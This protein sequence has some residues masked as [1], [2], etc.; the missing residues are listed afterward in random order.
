MST[1]LPGHFEGGNKFSITN[2][3][4][5]TKVINFQIR[6]LLLTKNARNAVW[7]RR[8]AKFSRLICRCFVEISR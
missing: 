2:D 5:V 8:A 3:Q 6:R 7:M 1:A 4:Y